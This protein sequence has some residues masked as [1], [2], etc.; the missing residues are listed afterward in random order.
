MKLWHRK[1]FYSSDAVGIL[2]IIFKKKGMDKMMKKIWKN[3]LFMALAVVITCGLWSMVSS[4]AGSRRCYTILN[5]NT[6]VYSN[7]GLTSK[8]GTIY[9][10]DELSVITV[11]GRYTKVTYPISGG[12]TK[13]G[14]ISTNAILWGTTGNTYTSRAQ[15]TTYKRPGG[16]SYGYVA[17]GDRVTI[18]GSS[19]GY[20]QVKYP[21]S[22]GY[23]YGFITTDNANRYITGSSSAPVNPAPVQASSSF[24]MPLD[25]ARCTW[26]SYSNWSWGNNRG[27]SGRV[28]HLGIDIIGSNDNVH[29]TASGTVAASG[30]NNANGNYV[31]LKHNLNGQTVT[32]FM[33]I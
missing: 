3:M 18:L 12:R 32:A 9:G 26:R 5:N 8:Y 6:P 20:T 30:W 7:T 13:T 21:V 1:Q 27:G 28:Y 11:T 10:S 14:Y 2:I 31:V 23:K 25:N 33:R 29:A 15:I 4:A 24:Q 17:T 22:G 19:G 16:A